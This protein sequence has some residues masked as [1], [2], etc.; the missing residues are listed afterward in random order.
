MSTLPHK[1]QKPRALLTLAAALLMAAV[2]ITLSLALTHTGEDDASRI[3]PDQPPVAV[4]YD[5]G[6]EQST[7]NVPPPPSSIAASAGSDYQRLRS[8]ANR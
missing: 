2:S 5:R 8:P 1:A 4:R 7:A 6:S 3:A